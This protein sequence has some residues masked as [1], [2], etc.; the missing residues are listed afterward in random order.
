[1][2][3]SR[4]MLDEILRDYRGPEGMMGQEGIIKQLSG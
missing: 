2:T 1:M 4:E 3:F